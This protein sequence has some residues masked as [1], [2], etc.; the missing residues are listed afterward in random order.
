MERP[1]A[2]PDPTV[3]EGGRLRLVEG[4]DA[5]IGHRRDDFLGVSR[6]EPAD[7]ETLE[8]RVDSVECTE[9][10]CPGDVESVGRATQKKAFVPERFPVNLRQALPCFRTDV[11]GMGAGGE[12][13]NGEQFN[14]RHL[15][16]IGHEFLDCIGLDSRWLRG[17]YDD[18]NRFPLLNKAVE[19][20]VHPWKRV[21]P[22]FVRLGCF[23]NSDRSQND[24]CQY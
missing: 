16:H 20:R 4:A 19:R 7:T 2:A 5:E 24:Q 8:Q 3:P 9:F 11:I 18:R 17:E 10:L 15:L 14:S 22:P 1:I 6:H 12:R 23:S 13:L 21:L